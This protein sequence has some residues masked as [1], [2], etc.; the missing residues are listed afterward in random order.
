[1]DIKYWIANL[2][3][4]LVLT[5]INESK[6]AT[7]RKKPNRFLVWRTLKRSCQ[8]KIRMD[9]ERQ[10][11]PKAIPFQKVERDSTVWQRPFL[12][13][14]KIELTSVWSSLDEEES[15]IFVSSPS[16][17]PTPARVLGRCACT[18][19]REAAD[20][21]VSASQA[22]CGQVVSGGCCLLIP[23]PPAPGRVREW[24]SQDFQCFHAPALIF[25]GLQCI[26]FFQAVSVSASA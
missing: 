8:L 16:S 14:L 24:L 23:F 21:Q 7:K 9:P 12:Q 6:I 4:L 22:R 20:T 15:V 11:H 13:Y 26:V 3:E 10:E 25:S 19:R 18:T 1:M 5:I 17:P 2:L